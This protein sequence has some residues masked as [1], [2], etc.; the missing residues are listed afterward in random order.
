MTITKIRVTTVRQL[1]W[2]K[3]RCRHEA[4]ETRKR[5]TNAELERYDNCPMAKI[6]IYYRFDNMLENLH[7]EILEMNG[8]RLYKEWRML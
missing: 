3:R 4:L 6:R 5:A 2:S 7:S 8:F 1:Q